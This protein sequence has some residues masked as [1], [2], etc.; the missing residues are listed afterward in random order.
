MSAAK[1]IAEAAKAEYRYR[2]KTVGDAPTGFFEPL[3]V[4]AY[5]TWLAVLLALL[6]SSSGSLAGWERQWSEGLLAA[7]LLAFVGTR[8]PGWLRGDWRPYALLILQAVLALGLCMIWRR[9]AAVPVLTIIVVAEC[10]LLLRAPAL[11]ASAVT[12]NAGLWSVLAL[13]WREDRPEADLLI[14]VGF[15]IFAAV[16][17]WYARRAKETATA[18]RETNAHLLA[19]RSLLEE[20][21]RDHERLRLARELHDVAG[22]KLTALKLNLSVLKRDCGAGQLPALQVASR[23]ATELLDDNRGVVAQLRMHDGMDLHV[24]LS[25]IVAPFPQPPQIHLDVSQDA[26]PE[27]V[28]QAEALLRAAQEALTNIARHSNAGNAW[29]RLWREGDAIRLIVSDDGNGASDLR[30]SNGLRGMRERLGALGGSLQVSRAAAGGVAL[31]VILPL[32]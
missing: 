25:E 5:V 14:Y 7:F 15:Q 24:A 10:A 4:S 12:L 23:L 18:L 31:D 22:H 11:V 9:H 19:T 13:I 20:S 1:N 30:E 28:A 16:T 6:D 3:N 21:A 17:V 32:N 8:G 27:N 29:L 2:M 26:R